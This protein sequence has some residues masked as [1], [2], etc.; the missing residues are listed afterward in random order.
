MGDL[1]EPHLKRG[2][3][4][5]GNAMKTG[6]LTIG[7]EL[8][9]G[10]TRDINASF[11]ARELYLQGWSVSVI[12][13]VGDDENEIKRGLDHIL[14]LSDAVVI[15]GGLGPTV[16][17]ITTAA[18]AHAFS[19]NLYTDETA[20]KHL[21][22]RFQ[23][24]RLPWTENNAKQAVFPVGSETIHNPVGTAWG[25][26]L[27]RGR[28]IIA[29]IP[30]VPAEVKR[31]VPEGVIPVLR[32]E[33]TQEALAIAHRTIR[34]S[35]ITEARV[36]ETLAD[37]D[38]NA[39]GVTIG[40]YPDF[41][42]IQIVLSARCFSDTESLE[43][44][45]KAEVQVSTRLHH[46]IFAY[47]QETIE[48]VVASSLTNKGLTVAIAESCTGGLITDRLTNIPGSSSFLERSV[49][50]YSNQAKTDLLGVPE[51][52]LKSFGAVSEQVAILMAQGV[53]T[54]GKTDIGVAVTGIA[55]P[56]GGSDEKPVGTVF[57]ALTDG[58]KSFCR[59]YSFRWDRRRNKIIASQAT[60]IMLK[61]YLTGELE[62]EQ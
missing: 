53:R 38:F 44:I 40:F 18:V 43:K 54:S 28:K 61:R 45:K 3:V 4:V 31:M 7:N 22:E 30:G 37:V 35:G 20:L 9:S 51:E 59:H 27:K 52:I 8:I 50:A 21:K 57:I 5:P 24:Y 48:G 16:D 46:Y 36:D 26:T 12:M 41:P 42:E 56:T 13:S 62:H 2:G 17:D 19:L 33:F 6:I 15:T 58:S 47:D 60:L 1:K 23:K 29:V 10:K 34:L 49:I 25:F 32:K 55:G 14:S 11:I 39:L